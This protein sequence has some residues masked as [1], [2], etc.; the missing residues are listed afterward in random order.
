MYLSLTLH[1]MFRLFFLDLPHFYLLLPNIL[2]RDAYLQNDL[3][4]SS[5]LHII[6]WTP[7]ETKRKKKEETIK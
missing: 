7:K 6:F 3:L 1:L 2:W 4:G 5:K